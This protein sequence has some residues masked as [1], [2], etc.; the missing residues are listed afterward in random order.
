M[1]MA[2]NPQYAILLDGGFVTKV[3]E[4][5]LHRFPEAA[6]IATECTRI[7]HLADLAQHDLLRIYFYDAEPLSGVIRNRVSGAS[8]NLGIRPYTPITRA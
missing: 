6:D 1:Q 8:L 5:Q 3:L 4:Q 7:S 2:G